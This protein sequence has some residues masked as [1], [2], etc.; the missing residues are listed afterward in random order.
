MFYSLNI[1]Y[2]TSLSYIHEIT[3]LFN[4]RDLRRGILDVNVSMVLIIR[5]F[6]AFLHM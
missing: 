5:I 3:S 4:D 1:L 2:L 6:T